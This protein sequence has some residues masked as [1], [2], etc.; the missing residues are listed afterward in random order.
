MSIENCPLHMMP[1]E[2]VA[3][4]PSLVIQV[5]DRKRFKGFFLKVSYSNCFVCLK[6]LRLQGQFTGN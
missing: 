3:G 1:P 4:G 6:F 5:S 2:I